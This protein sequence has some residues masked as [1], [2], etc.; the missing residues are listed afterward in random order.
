MNFA[1]PLFAEVWYPHLAFGAVAGGAPGLGV[2]DP[3]TAPHRIGMS[4]GIGL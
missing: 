4:I 1:F 2:G 3:A